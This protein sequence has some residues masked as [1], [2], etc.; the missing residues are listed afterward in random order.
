MLPAAVHHGYGTK[1][2]AAM[3]NQTVQLKAWVGYEYNVGTVVTNNSG[4]ANFGVL[5]GYWWRVAANFRSC[6]QSSIG[7]R[8]TNYAGGSTWQWPT[9]NNWNFGGSAYWICVPI[10]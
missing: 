10:V 6:F 9:A 3:I 7:Q 8:C 2:W 1:A 4:C 5:P